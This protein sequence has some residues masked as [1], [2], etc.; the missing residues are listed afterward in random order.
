MVE[1]MRTRVSNLGYQE[2]YSLN[3][4]YNKSFNFPLLCQRLIN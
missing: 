2:P 1:N 3:F 4:F